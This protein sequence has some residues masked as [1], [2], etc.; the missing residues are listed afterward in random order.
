MF[1]GW[2][3]LFETLFLVCEM[4]TMGPAPPALCRAQPSELVRDPGWVR[5][6]ARGGMAPHNCSVGAACPPWAFGPGCS[7]ECQCERQN[8]R[9]CDK[10]DGTCACKAGF[11]GERCQDG[12]CRDV[13]GGPRRR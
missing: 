2:E 1:P 11:G 12:E 4:C 3:A 6:C 7:E 5:V 13:G 9:A 10:K 8:T